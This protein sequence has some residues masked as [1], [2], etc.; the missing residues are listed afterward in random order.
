M[1]LIAGSHVVVLKL[2]SVRMREVGNRIGARTEIKAVDK[3]T[4]ITQLARHGGRLAV[5]I[6]EIPSLERFQVQPSGK[7]RLEGVF[8]VDA[9]G[10]E[11]D[12]IW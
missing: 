3:K 7:S 6:S 5:K 12:G 10:I 1:D 4:R 8:V 9:G 2:N 11:S